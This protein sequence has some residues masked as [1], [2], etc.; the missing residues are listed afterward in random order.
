MNRKLFS[1]ALAIS[2]LCLT[3]IAFATNIPQ[4][5][6][7]K[8]YPTVWTE[9]VY[10]GSGSDIATGRVV[11]WD[12]DTSD[13][14]AGSIFDDM[15][16]WVK[17]VNAANDVWTAGVTMLTAQSGSAAIPN[18]STGRI[19]IR[20]P[21]V[22]H[23]NDSPPTVDTVVATTSSGYVGAN[24]PS[25]DTSDLGVVIKASAAGNDVE[26][27]VGAGSSLIYVNPTLSDSS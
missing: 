8:N 6:D 24:T 21:A 1:I 13:S 27:D 17:S 3:S 16:P 2:L 20:G 4:M 25:T 7:P 10:N 22:V 26:V 19:I 11:E 14:D 18:G 23:N 5:V 15:C 12:F 9:I